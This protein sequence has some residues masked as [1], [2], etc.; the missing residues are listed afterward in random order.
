MIHAF[1]NPFHTL[2]V[3]L[4]SLLPAGSGDLATGAAAILGIYLVLMA[5]VAPICLVGAVVER[6]LRRHS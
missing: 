5:I 6:H 4:V 3:W 2:A 1:F